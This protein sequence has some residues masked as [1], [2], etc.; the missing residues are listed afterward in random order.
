[1]KNGD[2]LTVVYVVG[3]LVS[4]VAYLVLTVLMGR[5]R[6]RPGGL[7]WRMAVSGG[8]GVSVGFA[9]AMLARG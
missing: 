3:M 1:M 9:V 4:V 7:V 6:R 8:I 5:S 2:L